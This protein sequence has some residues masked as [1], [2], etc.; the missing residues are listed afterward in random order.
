MDSALVKR[1]GRPHGSS[2]GSTSSA[3][4]ANAARRL[5]FITQNGHEFFGNTAGDLGVASMV[6]WFPDIGYTT[7]ILSNR[8]PRAARVMTNVTRAMIMRQ[9]INGAVAAV[10]ECA[11]PSSN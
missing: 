11:P 5:L 7:I 1:V 10:Q 3:S 8:D 2:D 4:P 6:Y 9:T